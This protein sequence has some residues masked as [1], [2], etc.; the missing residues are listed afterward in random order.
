[1]ASILC[2]DDDDAIRFLLQRILQNAGY[3]ATTCDNGGDALELIAQNAPDLLVLDLEMPGLSGF[4]VCRRLKANPFTA[5]IPILM[6]TAQSDIE[7]KVAGFEAGADD[8]LGKPFLPQELTVRV[9]SLLRLVQRE[10]DRNPSS[11]L[12]GGQAIAQ[13]I[14]ARRGQNFAILYID[15]DHFK[16]FADHFGFSHADCVIQDTGKLVANSVV[17][18]DKIAPHQLPD[19]AGHIGGDDF[20]VV[21]TS[22]RA[23]RI[24]STC[25]A[26]FAQIVANCIGQEAMA[27][28]TFEGM[29]RDG[30]WR[31][32]PLAQITTTVIEVG[33]DDNFSVH[34][35][36]VFAANAKREARQKQT[37]PTAPP[38]IARLQQ[39][40]NDLPD[41][42]AEA[43][44]VG[45][46][47]L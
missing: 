18:H 47:S 29:A 24:A 14:E 22:E 40:Q 38:S 30:R 19:L 28:G 27:R 13:A 32:F 3:D 15:L 42:M 35:L 33:A 21:T 16:P 17:L 34:H 43:L 12:P 23:A 26:G 39:D 8:Y 7:S 45:L 9:A 20:L 2:V 4:E 25:S 10:S 31:E 41:N 37:A 11:G 6:V 5:R 1:M 44:A 46:S 36:G